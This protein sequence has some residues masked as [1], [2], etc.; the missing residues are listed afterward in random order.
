MRKQIIIIL[1]V[2]V[3]VMAG[4]TFYT[5]SMF[6]ESKHNIKRGS[7]SY[8]IFIPDYIK[9]F[10]LLDPISEPMY[11]SIPIDCHPGYNG[12]IYESHLNYENTYENLSKK[13]SKQGFVIKEEQIVDGEYIA[14]NN[15][16]SIDIN[17]L[18]TELKE[19]GV[20]IRAY[21]VY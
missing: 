5:F 20:K 1:I 11:Y 14:V 8:Y 12:V 3:V 2:I 4:V 17:I 7:F 16:G 19:G 21:E 18:L 6:F 15:D 10:P 13:L 9:D